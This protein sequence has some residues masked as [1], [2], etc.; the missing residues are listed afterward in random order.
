MYKELINNLK[1]DFNKTVEYLKNE[2]VSLQVGRATPGLVENLEVECYNQKLPIK[3]LAAI[4]IPEPR[5]IVIRPWDKEIIRNIELAI[6]DSK[7]GLNPIAEEE[8]IRVNI[9]S[10]NEERRRELVKIVQEK[11][12]ECRISVRRRRGDI[13][14]EIKNM[15]QRKEITEDDKFRAKEELQKTVDEYNKKIEEISE[16]KEKE[17]MTI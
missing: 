13:W 15:E 11:T 5:L 1:I 3:Q 17:I 9:P 14:D 8:F 7:L 6:K 10:L 4:N 2:L 16:K 12:E